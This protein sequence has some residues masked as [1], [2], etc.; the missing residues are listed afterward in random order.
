MAKEPSITDILNDISKKTDLRFGVIEETQWISTG[1]LGI[2]YVAGN[3]LPLGRSV[4]LYGPPSSGKTTTGLQAAAVLQQQIIAEK[5]DEYILYLDY[6]HAL[7]TDYC[8]A[9]GLDIEHDSFLLAQPHSME[10][11]AEAALRLIGTGKVRLSIWDSVAAMAPIARLEGE[12]DQRTAAMNKAR[13]MSGLMLQLTPLLH[14]NNSCAVFINHLMESV[15]MGG[16]PGM[17]P[18]VTT[19]GGKA[20]KFYA[21]VRL[22]YRQIGN[23][24]GKATDPLTQEVTNQSTATQ[25]KVKCVKNKV[26]A[27]FREAEVRVRYGHGFDDAWSA[28]QVLLGHKLIRKDG[29]WYRFDPSLEHP[30]MTIPGTDKKNG[31]PSIQGESAVL[32]F[33]DEHPDWRDRLV[34]EATRLVEG[35]VTTPGVGAPEEVDLAADGGLFDEGPE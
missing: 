24:K 7:D 19:P 32:R 33:A 15:E 2:N 5:R 14:K 20:L 4:E 23:A 26:A 28:I 11:G 29:A 25:V 3:G 13:L 12:F 6:E 17:P 21:S 31:R 9:L 16:R 8:A 27:P 22:E 10:Q 34:K 30:A 35:D 18:K 1:N